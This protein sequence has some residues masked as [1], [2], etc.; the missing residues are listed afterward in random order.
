M[1]ICIY[2]K[3]FITKMYFDDVIVE[4]VGMWYELVD[5]YDLCEMVD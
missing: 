5:M 3:Y 2:V 1:N 4:K